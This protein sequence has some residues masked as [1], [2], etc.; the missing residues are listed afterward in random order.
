MPRQGTTAELKAGMYIRT[1]KGVPLRIISTSPTALTLVDR[2]GVVRDLPRPWEPKPVTILEPSEAEALGLVER[3]LGAEVEAVRETPTEPFRIIGLG[4]SLGMWHTHMHLFH[5]LWTRTG[6]GSRS[7]ETVREEHA[8]DH[9][10]AEAGTP[11]G[12]Y[13]PHRH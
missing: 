10:D 1:P 11:L 2:E 5:G 4:N 8:A 12:A 3:L 7:L 13:V 6:P 9:A